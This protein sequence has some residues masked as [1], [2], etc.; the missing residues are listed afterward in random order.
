MSI[1]IIKEREPKESV[2]YS[3]DFDYKNDSSGGFTFPCNQYGEILKDEMPQVAIDN[4]HRCLKDDR[5]SSPYI[6]T[7]RSHWVEP[8]IGKCVCGEEVVLENQYMGACECPKCGQWYNIYGQ[9]LIPP[10]YWEDDEY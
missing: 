7:H 2:T 5:L 10:E 1:K 8:A 4:Y 9:S 3:L 6:R